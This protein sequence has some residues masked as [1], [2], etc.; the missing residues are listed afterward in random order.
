MIYKGKLTRGLGEAS[1]WVK[2]IEDV[3]IDKTN[4]KLFY[5]TLNIKLNQEFILN[6]EDFK[7]LK[8]EFNGTEDLFF[9]ECKL[10]G[11]IAYIIRTRSNNT[12]DLGHHPLNIIEVIS[13]TNFRQKYNLKDEDEIIIEIGGNKNE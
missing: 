5:G 4:K 2:K 8:K 10:L 9:K 13:G 3:F 11:E 12:K 7:I 6:N 1:Y